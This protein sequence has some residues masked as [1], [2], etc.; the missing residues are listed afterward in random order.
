[1]TS[2]S[3]TAALSQQMYTTV[4]NRSALAIIDRLQNRQKT[5]RLRRGKTAYPVGKTA[6]RA[7]FYQWQRQRNVRK[8]SN[9]SAVGLGNGI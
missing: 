1:M 8:L 4:I 9:M 3:Q 5:H 7:S 2:T 6:R